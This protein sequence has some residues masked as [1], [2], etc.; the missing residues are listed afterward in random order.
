M[1]IEESIELV[2]YAF[3]HAKQGDIFVQ[4]SPST[5]LGVLADALKDIFKADNPIK[6]LGTRHGEK[7]YESLI[8]K[9]EMLVAEEHGHFF[10]V[11]ADN[12]GLN[13]DKYIATGERLI[14]DV[15]DYNSHN[16]VR[17]GFDETKNLLLSLDFIQGALND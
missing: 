1:S 3:N 2:L 15:E 14:S 8:S 17:L 5:T 10:R 16:T 12:R 9:E 6:I 4:K 11:P 7:L 13:Y